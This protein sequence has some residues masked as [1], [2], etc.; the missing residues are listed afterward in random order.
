[1]PRAA[2][3]AN[4]DLFSRSAWI[5]RTW[6]SRQP[7]TFPCESTML[8]AGLTR[9]PQESKESSG[10]PTALVRNPSAYAPHQ[11]HGQPRSSDAELLDGRQVGLLLSAMEVSRVACRSSVGRRH[12]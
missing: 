10:P 5:S 3:S 12:P 9:Q 4:V 2:Q 8:F 1:M 7:R 6:S 11:E